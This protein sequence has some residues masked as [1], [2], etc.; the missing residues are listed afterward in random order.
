MAGPQFQSFDAIQLVPYLLMVSVSMNWLLYQIRK[1]F[2]VFIAISSQLFWT[3]E[4]V[5]IDNQSIWQL[6]QGFYWRW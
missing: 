3:D 2:V 5:D 6:T 1:Y 4:V